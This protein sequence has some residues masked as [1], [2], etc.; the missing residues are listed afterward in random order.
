MGSRAITM[1]HDLQHRQKTRGIW[2]RAVI[3]TVEG[4]VLLMGPSLSAWLGDLGTQF[5]FEV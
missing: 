1:P 4:I 5:R 2:R 3:D